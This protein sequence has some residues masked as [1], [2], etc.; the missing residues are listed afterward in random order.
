MVRLKPRGGRATRAPFARMSS[1]PDLS[2]ARV[3]PSMDQ[4][5]F[6]CAIQF[7]RHNHSAKYDS[8]DSRFGGNGRQTASFSRLTYDSRSFD[9]DEMPTKTEITDS[10][11]SD[12]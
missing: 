10:T 11:M 8:C 2:H 1:R 4:S 3:G 6:A 7:R 9:L 12:I 5:Q